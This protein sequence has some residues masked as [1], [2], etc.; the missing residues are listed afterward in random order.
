[1][2]RERKKR[3]G[4]KASARRSTIFNANDTIQSAQQCTIT[5]I[6]IAKHSKEDNRIIIIKDKNLCTRKVNNILKA[7]LLRIKHQ[8]S[9]RNKIIHGESLVSDIRHPT[10]IS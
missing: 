5:K 7:C 1:M 3:E 2:G 8:N 10:I 6:P 9:S 4:E